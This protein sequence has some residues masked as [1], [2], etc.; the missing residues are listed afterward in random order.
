MVAAAVAVAVS[1]VSAQSTKRPQKQYSIEQFMNTV[2]IT[3]A[4]FSP[5]E[6]RILFLVEQDRHL[7]RLHRFRS[8]AASGR[9]SPVRRPTPRIAVSYFPNDDRIL[10]TRDQGGNE[11]NHLYVRTPDGQERDLTP[12]EKLK[13]SFAGF[14]AR[15]E[16]VLRPAA[17]SATRSFFDI[18]RYDAKTYE[19]DA[20][21]SRTTAATSRRGV[22]D[23]GEMGVADE[24]DHHG[25]HATSTC[26]MRTPKSVK[27]LTPT[28]GT[29]S[30]RRRAFDRGSKY[31]YYLTNDGSEFTRLRRYVARRR[32]ARGRREGELGRR[33]Y[34][35]SR[36]RATTGSPRINEDGRTAIKVVDTRPASRWRC[37]RCPTAASAA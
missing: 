13:A 31:L 16:R 26:G 37:P 3:G 32:Q 33:L 14:D 2:S 17:T 23:D 21:L 12:G 15:R 27:H 1:G 30:T 22:P 9:R 29:R 24:A 36:R 6:S 34:R 5:D 18:Y 19:R 11:L 35:T 10:F 4:S 8:L 25:E 28:Q 7:E 20:L